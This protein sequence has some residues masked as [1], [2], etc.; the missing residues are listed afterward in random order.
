MAKGPD[1]WVHIT[2]VEQLCS[3]DV[4]VSASDTKPFRCTQWVALR[5]KCLSLANPRRAFLIKM[6]V[7]FLIVYLL[8]PCRAILAGQLKNRNALQKLKTEGFSNDD[9]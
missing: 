4:K 9:T 8:V 1:C 6:V 7:M 2:Q 3:S 5:K